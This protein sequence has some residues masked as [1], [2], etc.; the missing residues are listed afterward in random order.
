MTSITINHT[1]E[2]QTIINCND[3]GSTLYSRPIESFDMGNGCTIQC[4]KCFHDILN[5]MNS[6][7]E[8]KSHD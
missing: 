5:K 8:D 2:G 4:S 3:C 6:V 7:F 1:K